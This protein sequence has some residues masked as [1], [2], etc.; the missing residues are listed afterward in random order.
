MYLAADKPAW[1]ALYAEIKEKSESTSARLCLKDAVMPLENVIKFVVGLSPGAAMPLCKVLVIKQQELSK[2]G[3][4]QCDLSYEIT[5]LNECHADSTKTAI[6][7]ALYCMRP[8][9]VVTAQAA[10]LL[11]QDQ[12]S[13][14][15]TSMNRSVS[16]S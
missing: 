2:T 8:S 4:M 7:K 3:D 10:Q 16:P 9:V 14:C 5:L 6:A 15:N 1:E 12:I 11:T 13:Y